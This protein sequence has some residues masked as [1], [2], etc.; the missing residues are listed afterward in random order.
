M[1]KLSK[2]QVDVMIVLCEGY[3]V[4]DY[5]EGYISLEDGDNNGYFVRWDTFKILLR[6][7]FLELKSR[8]S[9]ETY[10]YGLS[11]VG[12]KYLLTNHYEKVKDVV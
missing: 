3:L 7:E 8:P 10:R 4:V 12:E 5:G 11:S 9:L 2:T 1:K 6:G